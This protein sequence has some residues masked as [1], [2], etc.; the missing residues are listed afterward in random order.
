MASQVFTAGQ[1]RTVVQELLRRQQ[2]PRWSELV[3]VYE[4][5]KVPS[6]LSVRTAE[7]ARF[8]ETATVVCT[9]QDMHTYLGTGTLEGLLARLTHRIE[10]LSP[11]TLAVL[12]EATDAD[13][14]TDALTT[15]MVQFDDRATVVY[16]AYTALRLCRGYDMQWVCNLGGGA[17]QTRVFLAFATERDGRKFTIMVNSRRPPCGFERRAIMRLA[18]VRPHIRIEVG[19]VSHNLEGAAAVAFARLAW[20][21]YME[22]LLAAKL[23]EMATTS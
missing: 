15:G 14:I 8:T 3:V 13:N 11:V 1:L 10:A 9:A 20:T 21:A 2:D 4:S 17:R 18:E 12:R 7:Y 22:H 16:D 23:Q 6:P 5:D 19:G